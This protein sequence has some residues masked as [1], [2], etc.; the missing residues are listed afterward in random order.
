MPGRTD[1]DS[2]NNAAGTLP[3]EKTARP[4]TVDKPGGNGPKLYESRDMPYQGLG[5]THSRA[6][7]RNS[8]RATIRAVASA[9][10]FGAY[11]VRTRLVRMV[12]V[13]ARRLAAFAGGPSRDWLHQF[14]GLLES[15]V[16]DVDVGQGTVAR[17]RRPPSAAS[18][19]SSS[20]GLKFPGSRAPKWE[21]DRWGLQ[22]GNARRHAT[23]ETHGREPRGGAD[24][25]WWRK[26]PTQREKGTAARRGDGLWLRAVREAEGLLD[27]TGSFLVVIQGV[28]G[29]SPRVGELV[30]KNSKR[31]DVP[32]PPGNDDAPPHSLLQNTLVSK[33][34]FRGRVVRGVKQRVVEVA[35]RKDALCVAAYPKCRKDVLL[36]LTVRR[37][38][39]RAAAEQAQQHVRPWALWSCWPRYVCQSCTTACS[40]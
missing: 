23:G 18:A 37:I 24:A 6:Y 40:N 13:P 36:K 30:C 11:G 38:R 14:L 28:L 7:I 35:P 25:G 27:G 34:P 16:K 4:G 12:L 17:E 20:L 26:P 21:S 15:A 9:P 39:T 1:G 2:E 10:A 5:A 33:E 8:I 3:Q 22:R 29:H 31:H 32:I 19:C